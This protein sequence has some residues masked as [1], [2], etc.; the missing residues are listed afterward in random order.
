MERPN[1]RDR[2]RG[3]SRFIRLGRGRAMRTGA[4]VRAR[5]ATAI[6][7]EE[8]AIDLVKRRPDD[9]APREPRTID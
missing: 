4:P 8:L 6:G 7:R 5:S 1:G 9:L 3:T 2:R